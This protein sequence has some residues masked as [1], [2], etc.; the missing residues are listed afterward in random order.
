MSKLTRLIMIG[1][2]GRLCPAALGIG[3]DDFPGE[4]QAELDERIAELQDKGGMCIAGRV[5]FGDGVPVRSGDDVMVNFHN[6][7][8]QPFSMYSGGY[9]VMP[10]IGSK[11]Y[12]G[13]EQKIVARA[14]GYDPIDTDVYIRRDEITYIDMKMTRT[15]P[16]NRTTISGTVYDEYGV[17][18][19]GARVVLDFPFAYRPRAHPKRHCVTTGDGRYSFTGLS[20]CEHEVTASA[21]EYAYHMGRVTP[22]VGGI[23]VENRILYPKRRIIIDYVYQPDGTRDFDRGIVRKGTLDWIFRTGGVDFSQGRVEGY[24]PEDNRDLEIRQKLDKLYLDVFYCNGRNGFYDAGEVPFDRVT[25]AAPEGYSTGAKACLVNHVY[26]VRTYENHYVKLRVRSDE[27][28]FATLRP[29]DLHPVEFPRYGL[30]V[31]PESLNKKNRLYAQYSFDAPP[32]QGG[33]LGCFWALSD[34]QQAALRTSLTFEYSGSAVSA[35]CRL[36]DTLTVVRSL[37]QGATWE[38]LP[39]RRDVEANK[40]TVE[41]LEQLGWFAIVGAS[42][43][44][45]WRR[46]AYELGKRVRNFLGDAVSGLFLKLDAQEQATEVRGRARGKRVSFD[47]GPG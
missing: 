8:D 39:T 13:K 44:N 28:L 12:A 21:H 29:T 47:R 42:D 26:V 23:A 46:D 35:A 38:D 9:F 30:T 34:T 32:N 27:P 31:T 24:E 37:D 22:P 6:G 3:Y 11:R 33:S 43:G 15:H 1:L 36:E 40:L 19:E 17:P 14:F 4:P 25:T 18:F 7:W 10:R 45:E 20:V 16:D 41:H 5:I 2:L